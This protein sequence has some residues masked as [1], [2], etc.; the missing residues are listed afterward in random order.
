MSIGGNSPKTPDRLDLKR[1]LKT[2]N[3]G[4]TRVVWKLDRFT[5]N[6]RHLVRLV[7][8]LWKRDINFAV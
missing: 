7:E 2:L 3:D 1:I 5:S 4:D 8:K 6:M